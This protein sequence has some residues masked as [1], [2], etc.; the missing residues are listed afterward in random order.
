M[1]STDMIIDDDVLE[2]IKRE[3]MQ[4]PD[5]AAE[6][7]EVTVKPELERFVDDEI[8]VDPGPTVHPF[9]FSTPKSQ[10]AFFATDGFGRGIPTPRAGNL[11]DSWLIDIDR[12]KT[13]GFMSLRNRAPYAGYVLPPL[14]PLSRFRQVPG[15]A[16]T[17]WGKNLED[18]FIRFSE[19]GI[20]L[21]ID[22]WY[23]LVQRV[24][25]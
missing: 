14:N 17:G 3:A 2:A 23:E 8:A 25:Q 6:Y 9:K 13:S 16:N 5:A 10:A 12:R 7:F 20:S 22:G 11:N 18:K 19:L 21:I 24:G 1:W 4:L 15:H